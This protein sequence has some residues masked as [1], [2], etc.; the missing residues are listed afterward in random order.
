M[1]LDSIIQAKFDVS[2]QSSRVDGTASRQWATRPWD[3]R[4]TSLDDL[5][6]EL[7][8]RTAASD[9][10]DV[11]MSSLMPTISHD[12]RLL[13]TAG[14]LDVEPTHYAFSQLC[15]EIGA[16]AKFLRNIADD[17]DLVSRCMTRCFEDAAMD[18]AEGR[19]VQLYERAR[20]TGSRT[21][22]AVTSAKYGRILDLEIAQAVKRITEA[23]GQWEV[24]TAFKTPGAT[25]YK[26]VEVTKADTTLYA[27]D[28]DIFLFLVDQT[29]PIEAGRLPNGDPDL[30]FRGF[31]I[32]NGECGGV[33]AMVGTF[34]YRYVCANRNIWGQKEFQK[35]SIRHTKNAGDRL[36]REMLPALEG[37]V[38]GST[39]GVAESIER[40]QRIKLAHLVSTPEDFFSKFGGFSPKVTADIMQ[41]V[42]DE[43]GHPVE[44][45]FDVVQG[46]TAFARNIPHQDARVQVERKAAEIAAM[47]D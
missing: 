21:L 17:G 5:I 42:I 47:V 45:I 16:P 19:M 44:S 31:Y 25:Q 13:V 27:S 34:L 4:F 29:R 1:P 32:Q 6:T 39:T 12:G 18:Q 41:Q 37:F 10:R 23:N 26:V 40:M 28:R 36:V 3:Q 2:Q 11:L 38:S 14:G 7:S 8:E 35:I 20:P 24:P 30:Y 33:S 22:R 15:S 43:E 9:S 46:I